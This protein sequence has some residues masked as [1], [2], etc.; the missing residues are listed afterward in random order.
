MNK[1]P[2]YKLQKVGKIWQCKVDGHQVCGAGSRPDLA[3]RDWKEQ[4][5]RADAIAREERIWNESVSSKVV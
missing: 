1:S 3:I 2:V 5:R 4:K